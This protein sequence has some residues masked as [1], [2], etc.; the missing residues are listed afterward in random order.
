MSVLTD[1][2]DGETTTMQ[3][4]GKNPYVLR[5]I[6]G[7]YDCSCPAWRMQSLP[8][9]IRSCKHLRKLRGDAA[10]TARTGTPGKA[11]KKAKK[12]KKAA[13]KNVAEHAFLLA[14]DWEET[15]D[16][17]GMLQSEKLDGV[18]AK[19]IGAKRIFISRQGNQFHAPE[20]FTKDLPDED[21]DG[22]LYAGRGRFHIASGVARRVKGDKEWK[23]LR[24]HVFDAPSMDAAFAKRLKHVAKLVKSCAFVV[25]VA[26][27]VCRS[28]KKLL[29][30]LDAV[31]ALG[32]EG[33]MLRD[34][35]ALYEGFRSST[36]L[37]VKKW[38]DAEALVVGYEP[39]K[40]RHKGRMGALIVE[41]EDGK[42]FKI[43]TGFSDKVRENPPGVDTCITYKYRE[44]TN[45]GTPRHASYL[46]IRED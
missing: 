34:K 6:G 24:Y 9:D 16:P 12:R 35:T 15:D 11:K 7:V 38:L 2:A 23:K 39:G 46:R 17:R 20:W 31:V 8:I 22:E 36:L 29:E 32:G 28:K 19:W 4:S 5:N 33:F 37:K 45:L 14:D 10:E 40:G 26:H 27:K 21:L 30:E 41:M 1:L 44:L 25:V 13:A 42:R 18:R 3:G 43:G